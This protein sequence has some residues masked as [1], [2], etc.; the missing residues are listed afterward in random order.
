MNL[1]RTAAPAAAP[2]TLAEAKAHLRVDHADEDAYITA[3]I[4]VVRVTAEERLQ[5]TL[6]STPWRLQADAFPFCG[7]AMEL[8]MAPVLSVTQVQYL[9]ADG[10]LQILSGAS[11]LLA[12]TPLGHELALAPGAVW[13]GTQANR[14]GAVTVEYV[15]GFG[16]TAASVPAPIRHWLL[17]AI[18]DLYANRERSSD[19][20]SVP[21][22]FADGLLDTYKVWGV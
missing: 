17:L 15:A 22:H 8:P 16:A 6:V 5:R 18:G 13:P 12:A 9:A 3:L 7:R 14:P 19:K 21:Q 2:L 11:Y 1:T 20:P 4:D 10:V